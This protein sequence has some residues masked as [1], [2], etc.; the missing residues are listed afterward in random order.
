MSGK[1]NLCQFYDICDAKDL[2]AVKSFVDRSD[3]KTVS[4][5]CNG[6]FRYALKSNFDEAARIVFHS[7][8]FDLDDGFYEVIRT[9]VDWEKKDMARLIRAHKDFS[10]NIGHLD[11]E[12]QRKFSDLTIGRHDEEVG[13]GPFC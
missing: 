4:W 10:D 9:L 13:I 8:K 5:M 11:R 6:M 1:S 12:L 3:L 7:E 2:E